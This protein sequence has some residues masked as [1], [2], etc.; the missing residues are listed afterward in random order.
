MEERR[1]VQRMRALKAARIVYHN[2]TQTR[3]CMVRNLTGIGARLV[4]DSTVGLPDAFSLQFEDGSERA[5]AVRWR[6][7][8]DMGVEFT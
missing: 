4:M 5:C 7:L 8:G 3:D 1:K 2:G 6:K